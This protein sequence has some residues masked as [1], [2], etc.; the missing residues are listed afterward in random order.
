[1]TQ[2][3]LQVKMQK[4]QEKM[5]LL[6]KNESK[7]MKKR[8]EHEAAEL[9]ARKRRSATRRCVRR[10]ALSLRLSKRQVRQT[11]KEM[12]MEME[13]TQATDVDDERMWQKRR[14][15]TR[16][17]VK[18][19]AHSSRRVKQKRWV[20]LKRQGRQLRLNEL[21]RKKRWVMRGAAHAVMAATAER[22]DEES[23]EGSR[24]S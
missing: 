21:T 16:R 18:R 7:T 10:Q 20:Q 4:L 14:S 1:M 15:A 8:L 13:L 6:T 5:L 17:C 11:K 9:V 24:E 12:E 23:V 19:Q 2:Q 3:K 22:F